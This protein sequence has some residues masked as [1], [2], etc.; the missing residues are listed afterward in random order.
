MIETVSFDRTTYAQLP[1][2]LEAG[3]PDIAGA[4]G[5]GAAI[6]YMKSLDFAQLM[7]H[8]HELLKYAT[9]QL[10]QIDGL[11]IVGSTRNKAGVDQLR[12]R[13]RGNARYRNRIGSLRHRV[14][15]GHHCC[16]PLMQRLKVGG[17]T[18]ASL[19]FL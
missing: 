10:T 13:R 17:T 11:R 18:R 19:A 16:M 14:P 9:E 12:V 8:E 7:A 2:R 4:I 3:T 5:L 1:N 15:D 6:D